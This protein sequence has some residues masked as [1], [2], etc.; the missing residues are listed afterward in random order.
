MKFKK[1][2]KQTIFE[3]FA[4]GHV[5]SPKALLLPGLNVKIKLSQGHVN[6]TLLISVIN[7]HK[8]IMGQSSW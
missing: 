8:I 6:V 7:N 3:M 1:K 2:Q 5:I 4:L